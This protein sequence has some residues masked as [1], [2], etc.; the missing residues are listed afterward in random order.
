MEPELGLFDG[1]QPLPGVTDLVV[2]NV[3]WDPQVAIKK[4]L[5]E[6]Y[7]PDLRH[8]ILR[9]EPFHFLWDEDVIPLFAKFL[10]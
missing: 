10:S 8:L 1:L 9:L 5:L 7:F 4:L 6:E 3:E 2:E